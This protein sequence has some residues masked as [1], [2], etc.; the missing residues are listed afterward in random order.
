MKKI[1]AISIFLI[2]FGPE[3]FSQAAMDSS[4]YNTGIALIYT[5][6]TTENYLEAAFYFEQLAPQYPNQWL[7]Y[8]YAGLS[9]LRASQ[10]AL[11]NK[12]MDELIDKAQPMID[13][14]SK[15]KPNESEL[16][17]LQAFLYQVR[18]QVNPE[19]RGLNY[20]QKADACLKKAIASNPSNPRA[21]T[22]LAYNL[23]Y[24]PVV[25]GGG[26]K[27]A[28]PLFVKAREKYL[29]FNPEL[30]F[31]PDWGEAENQLMIKECNQFK[32]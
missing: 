25:F 11:V 31:M 32:N 14:A 21:F 13:K 10:K 5:A 4:M 18:L 7:V 27:K 20:S 19:V 9:Y 22:L 6:K 8:Y 16:H 28:L 17:A 24:T 2:F 3:S 12:F 15:L 30:P 1:L 26:A 23:Y 29:A